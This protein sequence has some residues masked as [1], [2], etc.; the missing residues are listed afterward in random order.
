M[1]RVPNTSPQTL[2]VLALLLESPRSW[3]YGYGISQATGLRS[4]TLYPILSRLAE[5]GWLETKWTQPESGGRPPRHTYRLTS[6]G[7]KTARAHLA[8]MGAQGKRVK[9][10]VAT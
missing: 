7:A 3:H 1:P 9:L 5:M 4:G 2:L 6:V 10:V 8:E